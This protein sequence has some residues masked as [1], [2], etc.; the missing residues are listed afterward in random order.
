MNS[1]IEYNGPEDDPD[2][3]PE[4]DQEDNYDCDCDP[5]EGIDGVGST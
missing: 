4:E 2:E 1:Y 3:E 5:D